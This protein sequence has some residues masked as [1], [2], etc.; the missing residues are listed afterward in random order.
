MSFTPANGSNAVMHYENTNH[1]NLGVSAITHET[2]T[3]R[4]LFL[5]FPIEVIS[6]AGGAD[7]LQVFTARIWDWVQ[8]PMS[9]GDDQP[10]PTEFALEGAFPNPFNSQTNIHVSMAAKGDASLKL[11]DLA[12]REVASLVEGPLAA[13]RHNVAVNASKLGIDAGVYFVRF[14]AAGQSLTSKVLYLK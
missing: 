7:G 1:D 3:Y 12:G 14:E 5:G 10:A 13:G 11:F 6:G 2:D 9:A 4:T 8:R